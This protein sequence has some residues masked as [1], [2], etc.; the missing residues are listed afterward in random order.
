M[1]KNIE[2]K[3]KPGQNPGDLS[4][5]RAIKLESNP[6]HEIKL[7]KIKFCCFYFHLPL[8]VQICNSYFSSEVFASTADF[9]TGIRQ[10]IP[11]YDEMLDTVTRCL[12]TTTDRILDL[13]CGTGELSLKLMKRCPEAQVVAVDYSPR[14]LQFAKQK[15][16]VCGYADRW[17]G[18]EADFGDWADDPTKV[19][20]GTGFDACVSSLAIHHLMDEMKLK[21]FQRIRTSLNPNSWFWNADPTKPESPQLEELYSAVRDEWLQQETTTAQ[22]RDRRSP[23]SPQG[24]SNPD[25][26]ATLSAQMQMLT[27]AS[28][29]LVAVPWKYYGLAVFGGCT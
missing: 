22:I 3:N 24:H 27:T 12:P 29:N 1:R 14:M 8:A 26:L 19:E 23:S 4:F 18:I 21:L 5:I 13:G 9:D 28:F 25:Q 20:I 2:K 17:T 15:I 10:L 11:R 16:Q 6:Q 7:K